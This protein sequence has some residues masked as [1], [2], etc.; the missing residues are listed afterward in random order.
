MKKALFLSVASVALSA[1]PA[2][3]QTPDANN[4]DSSESGMYAVGQA[5]LSFVDDSAKDLA[6]GA[7]YGDFDV[8]N[9]GFN[10]GAGYKRNGLLRAALTYK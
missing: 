8:G 1:V 9:G 10:I 3:A 4:A 5:V 6:S 2:A 7:G